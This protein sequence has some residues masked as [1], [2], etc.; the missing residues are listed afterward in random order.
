MIHYRKHKAGGKKE[1]NA[2]VAGQVDPERFAPSAV[3]RPSD[4][5]QRQDTACEEMGRPRHNLPPSHPI[6][7]WSADDPAEYHKAAKPNWSTSWMS[8][9]DSY[10]STALAMRPHNKSVTRVSDYEDTDTHEEQTIRMMVGKLAR[11]HQIGDGVDPFV[12]LPQFQSSELDSLYLTRRC[13]SQPDSAACNA[14]H[15]YKIRRRH[16]HM[17]IIQGMRTFTSVSTIQKWLP[18]MLSHPHILLS[19]TLLASTWLDMHSGCSGDSK[20]TAIVKGETIGS[21]YFQYTSGT[22]QL[23]T[24]YTNM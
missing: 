20:R 24:R 11:Y 9:T 2:A 19:A 4:R 8:K 15:P 18:A 21:T 6:L 5:F 14:I 22:R 7:C 3:N 16:H 17:L 13:K 23:L 1:N 10:S 12:V